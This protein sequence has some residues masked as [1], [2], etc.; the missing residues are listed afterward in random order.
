MSALIIDPFE[1]APTLRMEDV[2]GLDRVKE[3]LRQNVIYPSEVPDFF[4]TCRIEHVYR[5]GILVFGPLG[6]GKTLLMKACKAVSTLSRFTVIRAEALVDCPVQTATAFIE[7]IVNE[8]RDANRGV[9]LIDN[10]ELAFGQSVL[11]RLP[12]AGTVK[13]LFQDRM[14]SLMRS[15]QGIQV[16]ATTNAPWELDGDILQLFEQKV[17]APLPDL[18]QRISLLK[19]DLQEMHFLSESDIAEIAEKTQ[20]FNTK[21]LKKLCANA[22]FAAF[23]SL[24]KAEHFVEWNGHLWP[25]D[26]GQDNA[27]DVTFGMLTDQQRSNLA[28]PQIRFNH[29]NE[30]LTKVKLTVDPLDVHR[31]DE[32]ARRYDP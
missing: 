11:S 12:T 13:T 8:A 10:I 1:V 19:R 2:V 28:A 14:S 17:Y 20:G 29:L 7:G 4:Q 5:R 3:I 23:E 25:C 9:F 18:Q 22:T 6:C 15:H 21:D 24:R 32:W 30:S 16:L 26:A 27:I 31:F